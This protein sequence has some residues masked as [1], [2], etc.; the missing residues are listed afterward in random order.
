MSNIFYKGLER[1]RAKAYSGKNALMPKLVKDG[2]AP[3]YFVISCIDSRANPSMIFDAAPG[4]FFAHKAMGA[5]VRPY[6]KGTA[7]AAALQFALHYNKVDTII[8]LGHTQCG[9]IKALVEGLEDPEIS[10][11]LNVAQAGLSKVRSRFDK[12]EKKDVIV[13]ETEKQIVLESAANIFTYPSVQKAMKDR[14][15][16]IKSWLFGLEAG[17]LMEYNAKTNAFE[18]TSTDLPID[19]ETK[20]SCCHA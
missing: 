13:S 3:K 15:I 20:E 10:S 1:F 8:V 14:K 11:F 6:Q 2:Q 12:G 17:C 5:I 16:E 19:T 4:M 7:L 9:A 18:V